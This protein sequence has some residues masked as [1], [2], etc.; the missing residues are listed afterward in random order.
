MK[1]NTSRLA[2]AAL[3]IALSTGAAEAHVGQGVHFDFAHGFLHP[4][5]GIDHILAMVAVGLFAVVLG[6]RALWL[7]PASFVSMM[8]VGGLLGNVAIEIPLVEFVIAV[9]VIVLGAIGALQW[10]AP[11]SV[12]MAVVGFFAVFHGHAHGA[13]MPAD[14]SVLGYGLGFIVATALLHGAGLALGLFAKNQ[15]SLMNTKVLRIG[16][17]ATVLAGVGLLSGWF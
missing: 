2:L 15:F 6:G 11:V 1:K 10:R 7:V 9:S 17:G 16:G 3:T 8:L 13:E 5:G 14:A 4:M 12:A